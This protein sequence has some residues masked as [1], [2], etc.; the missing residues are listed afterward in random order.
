MVPLPLTGVQSFI[1]ALT[2]TA[3]S[4]TVIAMV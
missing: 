1:V 3:V 4:F 2:L